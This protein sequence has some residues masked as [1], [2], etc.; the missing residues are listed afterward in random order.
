MIILSYRYFLQRK[1]VNFSDPC[2]TSKKI[3]IKD[4]YPS[5]EVKRLF[6]PLPDSK[7]QEE[8][9]DEIIGIIDKPIETESEVIETEPS[10]E[11]TD[12]TMLY[13]DRH[14]YPALAN[15]NEDV[16]A[17]LKKVTSPMLITTMWKKVQSSNIKTI[18]I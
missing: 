6:D 5:L 15:C 2:L 13:N 4:E 10:M 11:V 7:T 16:M 12:P 1:R 17:V 14:I 3:F 9:L 18:G 8:Y